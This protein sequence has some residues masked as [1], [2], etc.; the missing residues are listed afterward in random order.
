MLQE[1]ML[2]IGTEAAIRVADRVA[3]G[4]AIRVADGW[5]DGSAI[6]VADGAAD[7][8]AGKAVTVG[9]GFGRW[10]RRV[11]GLSQR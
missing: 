1:P 3:D 6:R 2:G 7:G 9:H 11:C 8:A 10:G 4:V 5:A